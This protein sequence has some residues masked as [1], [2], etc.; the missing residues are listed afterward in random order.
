MSGLDSQ[1]EGDSNSNIS[2]FLFIVRRDR[3]EN[4]ESSMLLLEKFAFQYG[5]RVQKS[6]DNLVMPGKEKFDYSIHGRNA[7]VMESH[8]PGH[9]RAGII[10]LG[11]WERVSKEF[12]LSYHHCR[13][14]PPILPELGNDQLHCG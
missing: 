8:T 9:L 13:I 6:A 11:T 7:F 1:F 12:R 10:Y 5:L 14:V 3:S 4:C 2:R